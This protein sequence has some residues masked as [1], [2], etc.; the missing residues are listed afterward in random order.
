MR[1]SYLQP[2]E[3]A[4]QGFE[5]SLA[6]KSDEEL[7][8]VVNTNARLY[9]T[10]FEQATPSLDFSKVEALGGTDDEKRDKLS[11]TIAERTAASNLLR[12]R[13]AKA[14]AD[15]E[16]AEA[17]D[18]IR[19]R[20]PR[21][22][23]AEQ[24]NALVASQ[25]TQT[26]DAV[27]YEGYIASIQNVV[28]QVAGGEDAPVNIDTFRSML[29]KQT[30]FNTGLLPHNLLREPVNVISAASTMQTGTGVTTAQANVGFLTLPP[31]QQDVEYA[32]RRMVSV[33]AYLAGRALTLP[34]NAQGAYRYTAET[35]PTGD[36]PAARGQAGALNRRKYAT[37]MRTVPLSI[38]GQW[39]PVSVEEFLDVP[40]FQ[41]F[42]STVM[43]EDLLLEVDNDL[44]NG[45]GSGD[46]VTG[47]IASATTNNTPM[48]GT[49]QAPG[50]GVTQ[51]HSDI[52]EKVY[53]VGNAMADFI[54]MNPTNWHQAVTQRDSQ[55]RLLVG[56][57]FDANRQ[58]L[59]GIQ[60]IKNTAVPAGTVL[61]GASNKVRLVT[62]GSVNVDTTNSH[63]DGFSKM[64]DAIRMWTRLG[65]MVRRET[66]LAKTTAWQ[67]KKSS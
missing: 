25:A 34:G 30:T 26:N 39:V 67:V 43:R 38:M 52:T 31:L 9:N 6:G 19:R 20:G 22:F 28:R 2:D 55:D 27:N 33:F 23:T 58:T 3:S 50:F 66:A 41:D 29:A 21:S 7:H 18:R 1:N 46:K 8:E 61:T 56:N 5:A 65:L 49:S 11:N 47:L 16:N 53:G 64:I 59:F 63:D 32:S 51:I 36:K 54:L 13:E 44:I 37:E 60:V 45:D 10:V 14:E 4:V 35:T 40:M 62:Q 42:L 48:P 57:T 24:V 12:N 15:R 17:V